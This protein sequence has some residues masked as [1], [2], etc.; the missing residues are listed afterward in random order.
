METYEHKQQKSILKVTLESYR[1]LKQCKKSH[2]I[3]IRYYLNQGS[4]LLNN[5][6]SHAKSC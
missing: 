6:T 2:L 1:N 5:V 4:F 3:L